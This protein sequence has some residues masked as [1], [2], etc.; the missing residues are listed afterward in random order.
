MKAIQDF[1]RNEYQSNL[2]EEAAM[3]GTFLLTC[4]L[5]FV[6]LGLAGTRA[7]R[8]EYHNLQQQVKEIADRDKNGLVTHREMGLPCFEGHEDKSV[9]LNLFTK[10]Q[11]QSYLNSQ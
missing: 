10:E 4:V 6:V 7:Q 5:P 9:D 1:M 8:N 3:V 2:L 11:L